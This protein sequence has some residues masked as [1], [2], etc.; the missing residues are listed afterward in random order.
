MDNTIEQQ[1]NARGVGAVTSPQQETAKATLE[2]LTRWQAFFDERLRTQLTLLEVLEEY[3]LTGLRAHY[4]EGNIDPQFIGTLLDRVLQRMID[5]KPVASDEEQDSSYRWSRPADPERRKVVIQTVETTALGFV[6]HYRD[7]LLGHWKLAKRDASLERAINDGLYR[8]MVAY[9]TIFKPDQLAGLSVDELREKI[10]ELQD[11]W[12]QTGQITALATTQER[13]QLDAMARLQLPHWLR[14]LSEADEALLRAFQEQTSQAQALVDGLLDGL[15]SLQAYAR[16]LARDYIK[17]ERDM[18]VE[19]DSIQVQLQWKTVSGNPVRTYRLSE[20]LAQGP[21]RSDAYSVLSITKGTTLR[22]QPLSSALMSQMLADVDA[23]A[24]YRQALVDQYG[25]AELK[26]AMLD[27]YTARLQQ[28]AFVARCAGHLSTTHHDSLKALWKNEASQEPASDLHV[29]GLVLPN[30]FKCA[31]LLLFY[32]ED[33]QGAVSDLLLYAPGKPDGQEWIEL[34]T[35][36]GVSSEIGGW[37]NSQ[38]GRQYLLQQL[39]PDCRGRAEA[40]F[41]DVTNKPIS[42][43][44]NKDPRGAVVGFTACLKDAVA[45]GL[46]NNLKKV[47]LD[48]SPRWYSALPIDSRRLIGSLNQEL[49]VHEQIFNEQLASFEVFLDFAKRTITQDIA[50]Y[51]RT[52]GVH[53]PVDPET[54]LIDYQPGLSGRRTEVASLLDLA[55]YGYDDNSGIDHPQK[56]VRSSVG[57]DLTQVRSAE[58]AKYIRRAYLGE[59][60]AGHIRARFLDAKD[61]AYEKRR[62]A[63]KNMLLV[64]MDRDLRVAR[65][66]SV[67]EAGEFSSLS[68]LVTL[69]YQVETTRSPSNP[70]DVVSREGLIK[71]TLGNHVVLGVYVFASPCSNGASPWLYTPDAPDG[72][73][74]RKYWGFSG[75]AVAPLCDYILERVALIARA[76]V[77]RSLEALMANT[78]RVGALREGHRVAD[79]R[80]EFDACIMRAITDVEDITTSRAEMITGLALKGLYLAAI[81]V[82]MVYPPFALL[83]DVV[84]IAIS[85]GQAIDAHLKGDTSGALDHWLE[86]SWGALFA[87]LG[88]G[89]AVSVPGMAARSLKV[90]VR[91]EPFSALYL[92]KGASVAAREAGPVIRRIR[93]KPKQAVRT[94]P[95]NLELVTEEGIFKGTYRSPSSASQRESTYYIQSKGKFY[96]VTRDPH[97]DGLCLVDASRPGA[98]YKQPIRKMANGK[99]THDKVGLRGGDDTVRNLDRVSD[100]R[101]AFPDHA[102]PQMARGALQGEAVVARFSEAATDNYLFSLNAQTCVIASLYNPTIKVGAV[103]HFDHNIRSLI[104]SGVRG[105]MRRLG[106]SATDIRVTLVGGDWLAGGADI[107][108]PVRSVMRQQGLRP[109]WDYWSYSSCLGNT[110]GV[111]LD[112]RSGVT[113]VFKTAGDQVERYYSPAHRLAGNPGNVD[114]FSVRIRRFEARF[115]RRPLSENKNGVVVDNKANPARAEE[116]D[117]HQFS[118]EALS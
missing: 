53:E 15:D 65:G 22:N 54:I 57:Q 83:L 32:R 41:I 93:F 24:G 47:E 27:W 79:I 116:I 62:R 60:Y 36:R 13:Q 86:A 96:Q 85:S 48:E 44:L 14:V 64:K 94:K 105:V 104:E 101:K 21:L 37:V 99:W 88:A 108:G 103:I 50:P 118:I 7:Y 98:L 67:L 34:A 12:R 71:F 19:P 113:T 74:F 25:R 112:L 90:A 6:E 73:M 29:A 11:A 63:F 78:A 39:D 117:L 1:G 100:L 45:M 23:P 42:W 69:L 58:L 66:K 16:R 4:R 81:P 56:G 17:R 114:S 43:N 70:E 35:L 8:H 18:D 33:M 3:V 75:E 110:Y 30:T 109:T 52:Q 76:E 26:D 5:Q 28:S 40:F 61:T 38:A 51:M 97:F 106:G 82:C 87:A 102:S 9:S 111:A 46:A 59:K 115:K 20:L 72:V 84:F 49:R 77:K 68:A 2:R 107:G 92:R 80:T 31:D 10:E 91:R 89:A 95:E 55:I